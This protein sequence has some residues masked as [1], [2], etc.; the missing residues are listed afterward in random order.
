MLSSTTIS[1]IEGIIFLLHFILSKRCFVYNE[2]TCKQINGYTMENLINAE[3]AN[4][5]VKYIVKT[6]SSKLATLR[7]S[8]SSFGTAMLTIVR[9]SSR[10]T[11]FIAPTKHSPPLTFITGHETNGRQLSFLDNLKTGQIYNIR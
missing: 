5:H 8:I 9:A 1:R 6:L 7:P 3:V 4:L 10:R 11:P 2:D